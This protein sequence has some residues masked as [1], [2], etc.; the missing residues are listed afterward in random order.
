VSTSR[1]RRVL[2]LTALVVATAVAV[3]SA[4]EASL[5]RAAVAAADAAAARSDWREA[6]AQARA[7]AEALAPGS[8]WPQQGLR[9][10]DAIGQDAQAR[11][12]AAIALL[13]YGA[14]R[15]AALETRAPGSWSDGWRRT[16]EEGLERVA[17]ASTEA[18]RPRPAAMLDALQRDEAPSTWRLAALS[19]SSLTVLVA[20]A[21]LAWL[22]ASQRPERM[23][24]GL[25]ALAAAGFV[26]YAA[27]LWMG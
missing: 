24:R 3:L 1:P 7:A 15:T 25:V 19:A 26:V 10:L 9:R 17:A 14:M 16:A 11:G 6:I 22:D 27:V 18:P 20:L 8:P 12:D 5:G 4:R 2:A 21:V 13:A 23:A